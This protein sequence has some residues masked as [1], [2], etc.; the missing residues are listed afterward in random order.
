MPLIHLRETSRERARINDKV[1][2]LARC[3]H[4][5]VAYR[6]TQAEVID[7]DMHEADAIARRALLLG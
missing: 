4:G 2:P 3:Q 5:L 6:F 7:D 1:H